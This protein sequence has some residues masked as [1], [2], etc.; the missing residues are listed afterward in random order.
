MTIVKVAGVQSACGPERE[1]NVE[2]AVDLALLAVENGAKIICFQQLFSTFWFPRE[3]RD[4]H[5]ELAE[6]EDGPTLERLGAVAAEHE[7]T[8]V[9]PL[10]ER[11]ADGEYYNTAFGLGPDP[12]PATV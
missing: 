7:V 11:A 2:R 8:L 1:K 6:G 4:E 3:K 5:F 9:C 12:T 10:F